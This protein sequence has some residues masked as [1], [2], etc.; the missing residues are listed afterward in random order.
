MAKIQGEVISIDDQGNLVTNITEVQIE[1][2][3]RD[4][5]VS[6]T[7]DGH[8]TLGIFPADHDEPEMTLLAYLR[9][10]QQLALALVGDSATK[11]L[12]IRP[13]AAVTIRW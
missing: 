9:T 2:V 4:D 6:V 3:P 8:Q 11:F 7:C 1:G 13:G 12:R 10:D 5:R